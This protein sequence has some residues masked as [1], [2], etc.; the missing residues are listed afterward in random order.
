M[1]TIPPYN[2]IDRNNLDAL[3]LAIQHTISKAHHI[4]IDTEFT[5][6]GDPKLTRSPYVFSKIL[7]YS[8]IEDRYR[9]LSEVVAS[10][11]LLA[12]GISVFEES[13][14]TRHAYK[15]HNFHFL[16]LSSRSFLMSPSSCSF[17][18]ENGFDFNYQLKHGILYAPGKDALLDESPGK[19]LRLIMNH[20]IA[21]HV[22]VVL[23]NGLLDLMFV[24]HSLYAP[25]P[26]E[27]SSF[28]ADLYD[29]FPAGIY[30]TK[31]VADFVTREKASFLAYLFRK[32]YV[33]IQCLYKK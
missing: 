25:L 19:V 5:G 10:H 11:A 18:A 28:I 27:L 23:H 30:D 29:L 17:L 24:Y 3:Q 33:P 1:P 4:A 21:Q 13:T 6:L 12:L 14:E 16:M 7:Q 8:N 20:M 26:T 22:P 9:S 31:Y 2:L 32:W 15:V